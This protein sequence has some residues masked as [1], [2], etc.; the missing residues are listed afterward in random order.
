MQNYFLCTHT[1]MPFYCNIFP[2][3]DHC[4]I[5]ERM[6]ERFADFV[7]ADWWQQGSPKPKYVLKMGDRKWH[8]KWS[9]CQ[10]F[11]WSYW[12]S[13]YCV[14]VW[15]VQA[16]SLYHVSYIIDQRESSMLCTIKY[17]ILDN[18]LKFQPIR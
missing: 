18:Y 15:R 17:K 11:W 8:N 6:R 1:S 10:N 7:A 13:F 4:V 9:L 5:Y 2:F 16:C 14:L 12:Q 3:L